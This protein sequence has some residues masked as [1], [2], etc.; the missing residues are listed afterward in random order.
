MEPQPESQVPP[1]P[2]RVFAP[3]GLCRAG[4]AGRVSGQTVMVINGPRRWGDETVSD[5]IAGR[6]VPGPECVVPDVV[7]AWCR[8]GM[9]GPLD[10][11]LGPEQAIDRARTGAPNGCPLVVVA[12]R[13]W[14]HELRR[15][16]VTHDIFEVLYAP[17]SEW[18]VLEAC[19]RVAARRA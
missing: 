2:L 1:V 18:A 9:D 16:A 10:A 11:A 15:L 12:E 17:V 6:G 3:A 13:V 7:V 19:V 8:D 14:A 4:M 5:Q